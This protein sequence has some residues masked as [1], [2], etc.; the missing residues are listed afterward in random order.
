MRQ[1]TPGFWM[2]PIV[3]LAVSSIAV[4][5]AP[6]NRSASAAQPTRIVSL[7]WPTGYGPPEQ[8]VILSRLISQDPLSPRLIAQETPG[9]VYNL[10]IMSVQP[11]RWTTT[12]FG[13]SLGAEWLSKT[14]VEPFFES[15]LPQEWKHLWGEA[16]WLNGNFVTLDAAIENPSDF[17]GKRVAL[18]LKGQ[19]HWAGFPTI[20]LKEAFGVTPDNSVFEYLGPKAAMDALMDGR[21]DVAT[22]GAVTTAGLDVVKAGPTL[23]ELASSGRP[24][25]YVGINREAIDTVNRRLGSPFLHVRLAAGMLPRQN[26][27]LDLFADIGW[28]SAHPD[29]PADVAYQLTKAMIEFAPQVATY[30]AFGELWT[31]SELFVLGLDEANTHPGAIRAFQ[32][33][34]LWSKRRPRP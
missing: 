29:L 32:E 9:Y 16:I 21:V 7:E 26:E 4:S 27:P 15:P 18:G 6:S 1:K 11:R 5:C 31:H 17:V 8:A 3:G 14:G 24:F 22:F 28:K 10:R 34:G 12:V 23:I 19:T 25:R 30:F 20:I 13:N 33:A 2:A